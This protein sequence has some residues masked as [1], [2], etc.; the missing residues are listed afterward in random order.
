MHDNEAR[1]EAHIERIEELELEIQPQ[2]EQI[3]MEMHDEAMAGI[4]E[5]MR[6]HLENIEQIDPERIAKME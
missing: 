2:I 1:I 6:P 3:E 4:E 5:R